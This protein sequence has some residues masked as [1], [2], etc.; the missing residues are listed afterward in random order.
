MKRMLRVEV[1]ADWRRQKGWSLG[2]LALKLDRS[3]SYVSQLL[4]G[5]RCPGRNLWLKLRDLLQMDFDAFSVEI[6]RRRRS[7]SGAYGGRRVSGDDH[8]AG[9][10]NSQSGGSEPDQVRPPQVDPP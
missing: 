4:S 2:Q 6:P 7:A 3:R 8:L 9:L 1:V 10:P 5:K